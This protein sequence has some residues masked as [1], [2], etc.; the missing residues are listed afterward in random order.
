VGRGHHDLRRHGFRGRRRPR[1][2]DR[3]LQ[4]HAAEFPGRP[5]GPGDA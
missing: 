5:S 1:Y 2:R 3:R 4:F